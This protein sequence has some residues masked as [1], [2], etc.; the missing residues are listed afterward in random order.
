MIHD[1]GPDNAMDAR[2]ADAESDPARRSVLRGAVVLGAVVAGGALSRIGAGSSDDVSLTSAKG[3]TTPVPGTGA[4]GAPAAPKTAPKTPQKTTPAKPTGAAPKGTALGAAS[5]VPVG[6][7]AIFKKVGVV[8]TQ[9]TA[10]E[11]KA[12][13]STCTHEKCFLSEV[14]DGTINCAC[15]GAKFSIT[16]GVN[17]AFFPL[18]D[19]LPAKGTVTGAGGKLIGAAT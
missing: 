9:P 8:V 1:D 7:G 5:A 10:G 11:F 16:D 4:P 2:G 14:V 13:D 15:H 19:P 6:G 12:F 18:A 17:Q 3:T